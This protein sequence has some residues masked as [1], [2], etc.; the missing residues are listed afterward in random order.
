MYTQSKRNVL[1]TFVYFCCPVPLHVVFWKTPRAFDNWRLKIAS[2]III[3]NEAKKKRKRFV[4]ELM[5]DLENEFHWLRL[6]GWDVQNTAKCPS[7]RITAFLTLSLTTGE[8]LR[9]R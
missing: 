1:S 5:S 3:K 2:I 6:A 9:P 7:L 4:A 8:C